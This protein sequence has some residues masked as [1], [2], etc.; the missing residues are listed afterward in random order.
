MI[1]LDDNKD[2]S[3]TRRRIESA[4]KIDPG[5]D[6][7]LRID[8]ASG[9]DPPGSDFL[10]HRLRLRPFALIILVTPLVPYDVRRELPL[11]VVNMTKS[12][13]LICICSVVFHHCAGILCIL[14]YSLVT[15]SQR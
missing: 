8:S 11:N 3:V 5:A 6:P 2:G 13:L 9:S 12:V 1:F 15:E 4:S 14:R 10:S 7:I